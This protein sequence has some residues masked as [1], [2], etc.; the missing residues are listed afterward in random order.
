MEP[1][2]KERDRFAALELARAEVYEARKSVASLR[3]NDANW[4]EKFPG[5]RKAFLALVLQNLDRIDVCIA[6]VTR[7]RSLTA[8]DYYYGIEGGDK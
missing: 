4:Q 1:K 8:A 7:D 6:A 2:M 3:T 5:V